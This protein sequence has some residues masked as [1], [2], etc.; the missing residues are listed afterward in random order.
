M[1]KD[2]EKEMKDIPIEVRNLRNKKLEAQKELSQ[3]F[4]SK[5]KL[6][7][8]INSLKKE[9]AKEQREHEPLVAKNNE[10]RKSIKEVERKDIA[11]R[12]ALRKDMASI[13]NTRKQQEETA[14][15][16]AVEGL[17]IQ[18]RELNLKNKKVDGAVK[19]KAIESKKRKYEIL[20]N[21]TEKEK[22]EYTKLSEGVKVKLAGITDKENEAI[23]NLDK[24]K[25]IKQ[26]YENK[27][28]ALKQD[29]VASDRDKSI[30]KLN[31]KKLDDDRARLK[32]Q[33]DTLKKD[34][35]ALDKRGKSI[36][37]GYVELGKQEDAF[38]VKRLRVEKIIREKG[39]AKE[40]KELQDTLAK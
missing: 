14:K 12:D 34:Q 28:E 5:M 29:R 15:E 32:I 11:R 27:L 30:F 38:E 8:E 3:V 6:L 13:E 17:S 2:F 9:K 21:D 33:Q 10:V 26:E 4:N 25:E 7:E 19:E 35:E 36:D 22:G 39:I 37:A 23:G 31:E 40:L 16:Q 24:S 1:A 18:K 20:C